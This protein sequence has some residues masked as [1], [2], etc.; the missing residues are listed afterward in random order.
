[1]EWSLAYDA[2]KWTYYDA[3]LL[4]TMIVIICFWGVIVRFKHPSILSWLV[5]GMGL[6]I[7]GGVTYISRVQAFQLS[8]LLDSRLDVEIVQGPFEYGQYHFPYSADYGVDY[9]E[10]MIGGK[11]LRLY[12]SG[13]LKNNRCYRQF[14]RS[15]TLQ[16]ASHLRLHI[17]WYDYYLEYKEQSI[18]LRTP[19][20]LKIEAKYLTL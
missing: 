9:R 3:L 14:Y 13:Y 16:N 17:Y 19:C 15:N 8:Q 11:K 1:M 6:V 12:H 4:I 7:L 18:N 20:I 2:V 10:I 5:V